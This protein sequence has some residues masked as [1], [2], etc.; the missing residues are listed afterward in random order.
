[1]NT[2]STELQRKAEQAMRN[3]RSLADYYRKRR[4]LSAIT[5]KPQP[6]IPWHIRASMG[7]AA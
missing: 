3:R 5:G 2:K 1:M 4:A 6:V 7:T